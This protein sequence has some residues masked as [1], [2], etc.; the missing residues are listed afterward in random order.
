MS[1]SI[2]KNAKDAFIDKV[3]P[4]RFVRLDSNVVKLEKLHSII[5]TPFKIVLISGEPGI[6]K[7]MLLHRFLYELSD[8]NSVV[9]LFQPAFSLEEFKKKISTKIFG[10]HV[11]PMEAMNR[12]DGTK[13]I[14]VDEAQLY[15][16]EILEYIRILADTQKYK[17]I[18]S[19]H[20]NTNEEIMAKKHF[21]TRIAHTIELK[22]PN[23]KE[24]HIYVQK[25]LFSY[26]AIEIAQAFTPKMSNKIY[27]FTHGNL[28]NSNKFLYTLFDILHYFEEK[29]P[30]LLKNKIVDEKFIEMS[31]IHLGYINA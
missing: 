21:Q 26:N 29:S 19:L 12:I 8:T 25:K 31:A 18:L 6:G 7:T 15:S 4:E 28:R 24:F 5:D 23:Q 9:A 27:N 1:D 16:I 20:Q 13:T 30:T 22:P 3:E 17:F 11:D 14:I 2:Y 10:H